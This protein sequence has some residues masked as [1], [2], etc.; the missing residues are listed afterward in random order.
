MTVTNHPNARGWTPLF[1]V[2]VLLG[3]FLLFLVQPMVA[4]MALPRLG[5][6]PAVWN[7]AMLVYQALLLAGYAYAHWLRRWSPRRQAVTHLLVLAAAALW[8]PIGLMQGRLPEGVEPAFWVPWLLGISIGPLFFAVAAQAPLVQ[9]WYASASGGRDPYALYA[10]SNLGSFAGLIAYPLLAEPGLTL[11]GQSLMWTLGY[12]ALGGLVALIAWR[13]PNPRRHHDPVARSA[14]EGWR[15]RATWIAYAFVPSGLMLATTTFITTDIV[16]APLLWVMPLGLYLLSFTIAFATGRST[17]EFI[18]HFAPMVLLV[19]GGVMMAG[20]EQYPFLNVAMALMLLFVAAVALHSRL[21]DLRPAPDRLTGFY[22]AMAVGGALGGVFAGLIA[23]ILFDWTYEYPLLI[24]AAG[25]LAPQYPLIP[26]IG[27]LWELWP[28]HP[29]SA[30]FT[31]ALLAGGI[32]AASLFLSEP[33]RRGPDSMAFLLLMPIGVLAIGRRWLFLF[34]LAGALLLFGGYRALVYSAEGARTRSYFGVYTVGVEGDTMVLANGT[35]LHGM[36]L[37]G[38]PERQR[39]PTS[40][41]ARGSGVGR[42]M[43]SLD[44]LY[45]AHARVGVVGLGAGTLACYAR[46]GQHWR[47]FEIDPNVVEIAR[48]SGAFTFLRNCLPRVPITIGD[49]RLSLENRPADSLDLLV[50]DAFSSDAVPIHLMTQQAFATYGRVLAPDGLLLVHIS[51]RFL[52]LEPVVAGA[53]RAG[54]WYVRELDYTPRAD[55]P[56]DTVS[57]WIAMTRSETV[58][59]RLMDRGGDWRPLDAGEGA[60]RWTDGHAAIVPLLRVLD[61][62]GGG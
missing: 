21:Y 36:Q 23:P 53:A 17:A 11:S 2:T 42:A 9:R 30:A 28:W 8:L 25:L 46:P 22:L 59:R 45:G 52:R 12:I 41:Y 62:D 58:M 27:R 10:A 32:V 26:Q 6:A 49:A 54:G 47:F 33:G 50:L 43:L 5:G 44:A 14:P 51:N 4:R 16:A 35:T 37:L 13:V 29:R 56:A 31:L 18:T 55:V 60:V 3:S 40:Y 24:L 57:D 48:D 19:F 7:S 39:M 61:S 15:R 20:H 1:V 34:M 38:P